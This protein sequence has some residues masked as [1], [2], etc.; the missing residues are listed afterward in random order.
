MYPHYREPPYG[1]IDEYFPDWALQAAGEADVPVILHVARPLAS[2]ADE[3]IELTARHPQTRFVLAHLGRQD[4][5]DGDVRS[6]FI[7]VAAYDNVCMDTSMA[8]AHS[9]HQLALTTFGPARVLYGSDEPFNLL[10]YVGYQ[11]PERGY[12]LVGPRRYHWLDEADFERFR[13][14][15]HYAMLVHLQVLRA[16]VDSVDALFPMD[17][18]RVLASIFRA[19]ASEWFNLNAVSL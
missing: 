10:R 5:T 15:A 12:R 7:K 16:L 4:A 11:H 9:V 19:N 1:R 8:L 3:V 2:C 13:H 6:A 18:D 17:S 14:L